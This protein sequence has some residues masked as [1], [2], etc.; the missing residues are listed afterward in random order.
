MFLFNLL[1]KSVAQLDL[2]GNCIKMLNLE[3]KYSRTWPKT[4]TKIKNLP[5][6][7]L[8]LGSR[9]PMIGI[10]WP[11][12]THS[13]VLNFWL[14]WAWAEMNHHP[15]AYT[16]WRMNEWYVNKKHILY[17]I[18]LSHIYLTII[19]N[20]C[21]NHSHVS[22]HLIVTKCLIFSITYTTTIYIHYLLRA[23][24]PTSCIWASNN[25]S[26]I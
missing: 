8:T 17:N 18:F 9:L 21:I 7:V 16:P 25:V 3:S 2:N 4:L 24:L 13:L 22:T 23:T 26:R 5:T 20:L 14:W 6:L 1:K 15:L 19:V 11:W 10:I 12:A